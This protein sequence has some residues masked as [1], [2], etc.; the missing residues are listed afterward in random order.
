MRRRHSP[1]TRYA[2][3][4]NVVLAVLHSLRVY[5]GTQN[6]TVP[7]TACSL[8]SVMLHGPICNL[9]IVPSLLANPRV[10]IASMGILV[11]ATSLVDRKSTRLNS[12][13]LRQSR[14]PSSA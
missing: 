3:A 14:M 13:H 6:L 4:N 7:I 12:S 9:M 2:L 5:L 1:R 8:F 11:Q 10:A